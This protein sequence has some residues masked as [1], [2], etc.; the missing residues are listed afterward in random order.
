MNY[1]ALTLDPT[2]HV[3]YAS[4]EMTFNDP[5]KDYEGF[6]I[7]IQDDLDYLEI[8]VYKVFM[9]IAKGDEGVIDCF[10]LSRINRYEDDWLVVEP[11]DKYK[12]IVEI[13]EYFQGNKEDIIFFGDG[14]NDLDVFHQVPTSVAMGNGIDELKEIATFVTKAVDEDGIQYACEVLKLI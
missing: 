3:V 7:I 5:K 11:D 13:V 8:P 4:K 1:F 9:R 10:D 12:G 6:E 2:D 14:Y